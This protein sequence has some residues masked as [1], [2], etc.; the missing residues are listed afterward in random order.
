[1]TRLEGKVALISG[2]ARGQGAA[3]G[4]LFVAEGATVVLADVRDDLGEIVAKDLGSGAQY[5]HLDVTDPGAWGRVVAEVVDSHGRIDVLVNNAGIFQLPGLT[6]TELADWNRIMSVNAT[7]VFLGMKT[8]APAMIAQRS[9]SIVN[10]SSIAGLRGGPMGFAYS[11]SK[12]AVRGMTKCAAREL[13]PFG[14]RV[15]SVHPGIIDTPMLEEFGDTGL[16]DGL[17]RRI[18][19]GHE[20]TAE[21]VARLVLFLASD[22][23]S[24]STGSE[25]VVDGGMTA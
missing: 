1:M 14:V 20:A 17:S 12:W 16:R 25:F 13:A 7:G 11:A 24:Y 23:S 22:D 4:R 10:I 3:E 19:L 15:N 9:G 5:H 6:T 21:D 8:V 2:G 18:P